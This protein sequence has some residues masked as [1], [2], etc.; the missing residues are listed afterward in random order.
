MKHKN[1]WLVL[2]L[3]AAS[4]GAYSINTGTDD[5]IILTLD[6]V[7]TLSDNEYDPNCTFNKVTKD[8]NKHEI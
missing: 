2:T 6:D 3:A 8:E 5:A 1:F 4:I 7:E